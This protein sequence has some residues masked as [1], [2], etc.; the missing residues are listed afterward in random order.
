MMTHGHIE[1]LLDAMHMG[2]E[3][4]HNKLLFRLLEDP[5]D[6]RLDLSLGLHEPR[7]LGIRGVNHEQID[8]LLTESREGTQIGDASV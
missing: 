4:S 3:A 8:P 1:H 2:G 5:L 6:S 7:N